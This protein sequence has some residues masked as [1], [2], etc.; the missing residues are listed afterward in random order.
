MVV[1]VVVVVEVDLVVLCRVRRVLR[2]RSPLIVTSTHP[3]LP[4]ATSRTR[5][6]HLSLPTS[7]LA[8]CTRA[9]QVTSRGVSIRRSPSDRCLCMCCS[10]M[11]IMRSA[12]NRKICPTHWCLRARMLA[13][14][15]NVRVLLLASSCTVRLVM[16]ANILLLASLSIAH[17]RASNFQ[18]S[19]P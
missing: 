19:E 10:A 6:L 1:V 3:F 5:C 8:S 12:S 14:T 9:S 2:G 11:R 4:L 16:R 15:S 17:V 7:P 13:T 18:P